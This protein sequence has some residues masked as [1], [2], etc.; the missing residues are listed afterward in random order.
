VGTVKN[1]LDKLAAELE[2]PPFHT[3]LRPRAKSVDVERE[4]VGVAVIY[5]PELSYDSSRA[6][7]HGGVVAALVDIAGY[8]TVAIWQKVPTPTTA[9]H[10]EYL[11][12]A[13]GDEL[14]ARGILRRMGRSVARVDIEVSAG[15]K[16]VALGRATYSTSGAQG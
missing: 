8:A 16:L 12:P 14:L 3:W 13:I 11:R 7:F 2:R 1:A 6:I 10:V 4:E 15:G 5:R 9:L